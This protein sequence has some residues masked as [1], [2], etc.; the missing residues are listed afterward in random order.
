MAAE[1]LF[2]EPVSCDAAQTCS[3]AYQTTTSFTV[4]FTVGIG[5]AVT[6]W[7]TGGFAVS[8]QWTTGNTYTCAGG[9]GDTVCTWYVN[10][11]LRTFKLPPDPKYQV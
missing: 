3:T 6:E 1:T 10:T 5:K 8:E 11:E 4:Q 2:Q 7:I 9:S